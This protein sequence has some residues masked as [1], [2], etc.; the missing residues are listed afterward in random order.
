MSTFDAQKWLADIVEALEYNST[1]H[2]ARYVQLATIG[3]SGKPAVRNVVFRG[4]CAD[5]DE[6]IIHTDMRS[7]KIQQL[8]QHPEVE[9][10]WYF[11]ESRQQFRISGKTRIISEH[12]QQTD[13]RAQHWISLSPAMR[14]SY[15]QS[16]PGTT[17]H[18]QQV[19]TPQSEH[20]DQHSVPSEYFALLIIKPSH[21]DYL[22]LSSQPHIRVKH[23][24]CADGQW[25]NERICP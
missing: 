8:Q 12:S 21:V 3:Q 13:L 25:Y 15:S 22:D 24:L 16:A 11:T 17:Y 23:Q 14:S 18:P 7:D 6:F 10:C 9:L 19:P 20:A 5:S 1:H 2:H 4:F